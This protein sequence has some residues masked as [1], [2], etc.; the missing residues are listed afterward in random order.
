[1]GLRFLPFRRAKGGVQFAGYD[2][3][4]GGGELYIL[5]IATR[6]T[7]G[8]VKIGNNLQITDDGDLS[9]LLNYGDNEIII[10]KYGN[11]ILYQRIITAQSLSTLPSVTNV[12]KIVGVSGVIRTTSTYT[13][14]LN[15]YHNSN[16]MAYF[17]V[18]VDN[19]GTTTYNGTIT[20]NVSEIIVILTYTKRG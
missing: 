4:D 13:L 15:Y 6:E 3:K 20:A 18:G 1:M 10:G 2:G 17:M 11:D 12:S 19:N 5:P 9:L 8:G 7:V 14:P 16:D